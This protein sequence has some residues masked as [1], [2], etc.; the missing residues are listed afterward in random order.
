VTIQASV[1]TSTVDFVATTLAAGTGPSAASGN[2][3]TAAIGTTLQPFVVQIGSGGASTGSHIQASGTAAYGNIAVNWTVLQ[4]GG[5]LATTQTI[6]D[7][8]GRTSNTLTL[9]Q[10]PGVNLVQASIAGGGSVTF[11]AT[12]T[13]KIDAGSATFSIVS[14]NNQSL[15]PGN[16]SQPLVVKLATTAGDPISNAGIQ[17]T[18]SNANGN[19]ANTTTSTGSDGTS[20]NVLT[21]VLPGDYSV[22][23][24]LVGSTNIPALTFNFSNGV[25]NLPGLSPEQTSVANVIDKACPALATSTAPLTPQQQDFLQRCSEVVVG[26]NTDSQQVPGALDAMLNNKPLPQR[27]WRKA[28]NRGNSTTSIRASP[29]YGR[30]QPGSAPVA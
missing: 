26:S 17:W 18:V 20:Q 5:T 16:A 3:Q 9:G 29:S 7:A 1:G 12:A 24:Q 27:S 15:V 4:G 30:A 23:A 13:A 10:T 21:V 28:C 22:T 19:L 11:T 8:N 25:A 14:G 6:T 2:N